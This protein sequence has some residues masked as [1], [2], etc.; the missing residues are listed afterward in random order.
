M[1]VNH[2]MKS[3][4]IAAIAVLAL[5]IITFAASED[6][7]IE[8]LKSSDATIK[9]KCDACRE[10][11]TFGTAKAVPHLAA[12]L[13]DPRMT[14]MACYGLEPIQDPSVDVALR[15]A[16]TTLKGRSLA[17]V[18]GAVGVRGDVEAAEAMV[19]L[20]ENEDPTVVHAAA[21]A[22]GN[23]PSR[24]AVRGLF[25]AL[26]NTTGRTRTAVCEG[27]FKSAEGLQRRD[28]SRPAVMLYTRLSEIEDAPHFIKTG[29]LRGRIL[30]GNDIELLAASLRADDYL[31]FAAA[32]RTSLE[33]S[34]DEIV[35]TL[36]DGL[37]TESNADRRVMLISA[38]AQHKATS[39]QSLLAD[40]AREAPR[41][42]RV[43]AIQAF[44][45]IRDAQTAV[46]LL[47]SL[48]EDKDPNIVRAVNTSLSPFETKA[49]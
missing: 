3:M 36:I 48:Q 20:L 13:S 41:E 15:N 27:I 40:L 7:L 10:L 44:A 39:A 17:C 16:L 30:A 4:A 1:H 2:T 25:A 33:M 43:A 6:E 8:V 21:R 28:M 34:S 31:S 37:K 35:P 5:P 45:Q 24:T 18:A 9:A 11:A 19:A 38:L 49:E 46:P 29:A 22:L 23:I 14:H 12:L 26:P 42:V 47:K 32:V